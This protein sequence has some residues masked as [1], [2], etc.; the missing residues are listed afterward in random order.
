MMLTSGILP[1]LAVL[2]TRRPFALFLRHAERAVF[3]PDEPFADVGLTAAGETQARALARHLPGPISWAAVSPLR[4][5]RHTAMLMLDLPGEAD[6]R[7]GAPGPWVT[8]ERAGGELFTELGTE[9][10]VRAQIAGQRWPFLRGAVEGTRLLL[11][12]ALERFAAGRG[13]GICIS[14][15]AVLMPAIATLTG[16]SFNDTWL[17]P[18]DGFALQND[19]SGLICIWRGNRR[20]A[21][22]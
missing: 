3:P 13:S 20:E 2:D 10:T 7:L 17:A 5:C 4:R 6:T 22:C 11:D 14:H 16:E 12:A 1:T 8:D 15:D 18:L 19:P 21:A 9:G